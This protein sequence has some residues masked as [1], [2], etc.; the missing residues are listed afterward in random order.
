MVCLL[1]PTQ[2]PWSEPKMKA[3]ILHQI[4]AP[5]T[6]EEITVAEPAGHEVL[7]RT[8]ATGVCHSDL[9]Y[10]EGISEHG[11]L[12][13][14]LGHEAAGV[15]EEVGPLVTEVQPGDH[16]IVCLSAFCGQCEY[17]LVGRTN[18]CA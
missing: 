6:I 12:P 13:G 16:V 10:I 8:V 17:C 9:H 4:N 11:G 5:L 3:A 1:H 2:F 7:V 18:L 15:V 14:V